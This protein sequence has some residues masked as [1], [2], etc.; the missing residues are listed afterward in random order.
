[1][2][3]LSITDNCF[4]Q[5]DN[6]SEEAYKYYNKLSKE[7]TSKIFKGTILIRTFL[8]K[9]SAFR[10]DKDEYIAQLKKLTTNSS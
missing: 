10:I 4:F 9:L 5:N 7:G 3:I 8:E 1:L 6:I 2:R